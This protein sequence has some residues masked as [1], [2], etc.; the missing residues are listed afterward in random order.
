MNIVLIG[1]RGT[2]KS[3]VAKI[4]SDKTGMPVF[5]MDARIVEKA[6]MS[7]PDIVAD[8][9][10]DRFRDLET[11]VAVEASQKDKCIIDTGG[12][13]ITRT[14]NMDVLRKNAIVFWLKADLHTILSRIESSEDRPSL[15]GKK[16]FLEE[17]ED[18]LKERTPKYL[19]SA[20][21]SI[22]TAPYTPQQIAERIISLFKKEKKNYKK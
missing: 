9:G 6:G 16:S 1:Y 3:T 19:S 17:V 4:I 21:F 12:G 14:E 8:N 18:V 2:G 10:W 15:T 5:G 20:D 13:I 7:I 22:D 11:E